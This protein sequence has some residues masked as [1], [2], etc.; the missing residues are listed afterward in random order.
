[1]VQSC[2]SLTIHRSASQLASTQ[3]VTWNKVSNKV[4]VLYGHPIRLK[5]DVWRSTIQAPRD[6][7]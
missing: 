3:P 4:K 1:M 7:A 6:F 5:D 2:Y